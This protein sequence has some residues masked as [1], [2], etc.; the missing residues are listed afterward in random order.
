MSFFDTAARAKAYLHEHGRVSLRALSREFALDDDALEELI[1]ELVEIQHVAA[2]DGKALAWIGDA[3]P[4]LLKAEV[5]PSRPERD[6]RAYTPKHLADKIL[7]SKSALEGERKQVTVLFADVKGSMELA[8]HMDPEEWS[9]IMQRFFR[10]LSEGVERFEGFVDKFTGDGIMALFGAPITHEDHAQRACYAALY[11]QDALRSYTEELKRTRGLSFAVRM[12]LNSA[13]VVVGTIGRIGDDVRMEY[14]AQGHTA[15]LASRMEQLADPGKAYLT[16]HTARLVAGYFRLR[17]LGEFTVKGVAAPLRVHE[18]EGTGEL[19]TRLDRSRSRGLSKFVG[20]ATEMHTLESALQQALTGHGQVVGV[21][22]DAGTGKSRLCFELAEACRA[23]GIQVRTT[24]G[25]AHGKA[26]PL[27]PV[28]EFYR[29]V[30]GITERDDARAARQKIAGSVVQGDESLVASLPLLFDLL[31]VPDPDKPVLLEPGP[32]RQRALLGALKR[33]TL[34][35]SRREPAVI[36]FEDLHWIDEATGVFLENLVDAADASRTLLVVNFRPEYRADWMRRSYYQ[37]LA[38]APLDAGAFAEMLGETLGPD[39]SVRDLAGRIHARSGG[40]PFFAEE[41]VQS[42]IESG[43]LVGTTGAYRLMGDRATLEIPATVQ[44]VLAA[45]ID[46]LGE[47]EKTVLQT[48]SVIGREFSASL[49]RRVANLEGD[50]LHADLRTLVQAEFLHET[51]L[52]PEA[53]YAFKHPLTQEVALGSQLRERRARV[54]GA[55]AKALVEIHAGTLDE[56]A[57]LLAHHCEAAGDL[58]EAARWHE[59]AAN[60]LEGRDPKAGQHHWEQLLELIGA[61]P[62]SPEQ[63]HAALR[64]C[65]RLIEL[66]VGLGLDFARGEALYRR[67]RALA[68]RLDEP[69]LEGALIAC[70]ARLA[71]FSGELSLGVETGEEALRIAPRVTDP[72]QYAELLYAASHA[73]AQ[74]GRSAEALATID[75]ALASGKVTSSTPVALARLLSGHAGWLVVVGRL[76]DAR[77]SIDRASDLL[78]DQ[79]AVLG[80]FHNEVGRVQE[81]TARG[82]PD[83]SLERMAILVARTDESGAH[84][85]R[86]LARLSLTAAHLFGGRPDAALET[87]AAALE[88]ASET[89]AALGTLLRMETLR[90]RTLLARGDV[91]AARD[92]IERLGVGRPRNQYAQVTFLL[93]QAEVQIAADAVGERARI[94]LSLR[95]AADLAERSGDPGLQAAM[96]TQRAHL[97]RALGD[98]AGWQRDLREALRIYT[99]MEAT[100]WMERIAAE[101]ASELPSLW[102]P[103]PG[104]LDL[105]QRLWRAA[106]HNLRELWRDASTGF[107]LLQWLRR[108]ADRVRSGCSGGFPT[109]LRQ[110]G[111]RGCRARGS[112]TRPYKGIAFL[113]F[114]HSQ[115]PRRQ[116]PAIEVRPRRRAQAGHRALRRREGLDGAGRAARSGRVAH[117]PR[118]LLRRSSPTACIA[119]KAR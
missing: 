17:D 98:G 2:R 40:N 31:G 36:L 7:Q 92:L 56:H 34:A 72:V 64:G 97:A 4:S 23:Q 26:V 91:A 96:W 115:T 101:L 14:T 116:N 94:E 9:Q 118:S 107:S 112:E 62:A 90:A 19:R 25:V 66:G 35:R 22:A 106:R 1:E 67:G 84:I 111:T 76:A 50:A 38:L 6:P 21:V 11:L 110:G 74:T 57:A 24:T 85:Y 52:Y 103:A 33:L 49:V 59:R 39:M 13:E 46:R 80:V 70:F 117:D 99:A 104:W 102:T 51:A 63:A 16:D 68:A 75:A 108:G 69:D 20:R 5:S 28:L 42:L 48:A 58:A 43:A 37:Q 65:A 41:I 88:I 109:R 12:G 29:G 119:S 55:V 105:L 100:G 45:R 8:E 3:T 77:A 93:A 60:W 53:E 83:G 10:I 113:P 32:E 87:I 30:F 54:H 114:L 78:A 18:L 79:H 27:L 15:G 82:F 47:R 44:L 73:L 95:E 61:E 89:R 86:V 71:L 81:L